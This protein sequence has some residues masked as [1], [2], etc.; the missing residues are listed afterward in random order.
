L[1]QLTIPA[2]I[3]EIGG[4]NHDVFSH[5][6][7]IECVTLT[8]CPLNPAVVMAVEPALASGAKIVSRLLA[9]Q[10]V[11]RFTILAAP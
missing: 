6:A 5:L 2:N 3:A 4:P 8:G 10:K 7:T 1:S 11:G 9:G